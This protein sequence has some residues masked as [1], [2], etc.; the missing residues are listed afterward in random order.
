MSLL[1]FSSFSV[2]TL[3]LT[4]VGR[5]LALEQQID[6]ILKPS[7]SRPRKRKKNDGETVRYLFWAL[8]A[9]THPSFRIWNDIRTRKLLA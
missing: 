1:S 3:D 2:L 9:F 4:T 6:A 5:K 7:K 8:R